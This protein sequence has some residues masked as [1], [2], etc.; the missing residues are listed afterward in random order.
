MN[1]KIVEKVLIIANR[2]KEGAAE[3][4]AEIENWLIAQKIKAELLLF[5]YEKNPPPLDGCDMAISL[6]GD[7]TVLYSSRLL[8]KHSTPILPINLGVFGFITEITRDE[9]KEEF[10][11]FRRGETIAGTRMLLDIE[12]IRDDNVVAQFVGLNDAVVAASGISKLV[13]LSVFLSGSPL[14]RYRADGMIVA[15][16]TGSTAYSVAAGGPILYPEM[17]AMV[18]N[19]ICPFSISH[20]PLVIPGDEEIRIELEA[21]QRTNVIITVDGQFEYMLRPEDAVTV[22]SHPDKA[23]IIRSH[24]RTFYEILR[25]K[26]NLSGLPNA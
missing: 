5:P 18:L 23:R 13:R 9:W 24:K 7:G 12:V 19:P 16:P 6:G 14:G 17:E 15:T 4:A 1:K 22:R 25:S 26:L 21:M 8:S 10:E 2:E 20:R 3:L 11:R